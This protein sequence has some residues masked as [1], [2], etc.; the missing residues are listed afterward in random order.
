MRSQRKNEYWRI[1]QIDRAYLRNVVSPA[2]KA[3]TLQ[4]LELVFEDGHWHEPTHFIVSGFDLS[5]I[6]QLPTQEDYPKG[7]HMPMGIGVPPAFQ[8]YAELAEKPSGQEPL[9]QP[10]LGCRKTVGWITARWDWTVP[11]CI[12]MR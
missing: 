12:G 3:K 4:E 10:P 8:S 5:E 11:S 9:L 2:D 6:P 7:F 1:S